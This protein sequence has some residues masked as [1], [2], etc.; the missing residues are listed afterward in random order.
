MHNSCTH[1]KAPILTCHLRGP[2]NS[3]QLAYTG[4]HVVHMTV[5]Y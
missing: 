5:S 3:M 1:R 4:M 2:Q